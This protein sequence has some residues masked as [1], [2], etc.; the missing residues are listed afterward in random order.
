MWKPEITI[1]EFVV[2]YCK[3]SHYETVKFTLKIGVDKANEMC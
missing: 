3:A 2:D 1:E